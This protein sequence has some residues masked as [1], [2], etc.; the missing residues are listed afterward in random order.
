MDSRW[1]SGWQG[2]RRRLG[3]ASR[4]VP[5]LLLASETVH[6]IML[7][8]TMLESRRWGT[9][10][11]RMTWPCPRVSRVP[12]TRSSPIGPAEH[13]EGGSLWCSE[14]AVVHCSLRSLIKGRQRCPSNEK[15]TPAP[16]SMREEYDLPAEVC[17]FFVDTFE[18]HV[19]QVDI[20][21]VWFSFTSDEVVCKRVEVE[22]W[23][24]RKTATHIRLGGS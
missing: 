16:G 15:A 5:L 6:P 12:H 20:G 23:A 4:R 19:D 1:G 22:L 7:V 18:S 3:M 21:K 24:G 17:E 14:S 13:D 9:N 2:R 11:L 8:L 10:R